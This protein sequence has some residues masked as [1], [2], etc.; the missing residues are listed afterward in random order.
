MEIKIFEIE[1][2]TIEGFADSYNLVMEVRERHLRPSSP[3]GLKRYYAR[4]EKSEIKEGC[5]LSSTCGNGDT[6]EEAINNYAKEISGNL[7]VI[8][9][10]GTLRREIKVPILCV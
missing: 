4:F 2:K 9:A 10:T 1:R 5:I 8:N 3:A 6:Y 7:L